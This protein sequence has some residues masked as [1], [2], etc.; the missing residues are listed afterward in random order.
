MPTG[1]EAPQSLWWS[2]WI[3]P[4]RTQLQMTEPVRL[5]AFGGNRYRADGV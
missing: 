5:F 4:I 2:A 1:V 3:S